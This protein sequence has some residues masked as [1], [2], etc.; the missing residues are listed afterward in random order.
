M[1]KRKKEVG[2]R[3]RPKIY[4]SSVLQ[5][6]YK[7]KKKASIEEDKTKGNDSITWLTRDCKRDI[8]YAIA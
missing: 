2:I 1:E 4:V 3:R 7:M 8:E 5:I 6:E